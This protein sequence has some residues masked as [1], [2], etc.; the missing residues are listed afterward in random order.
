MLDGAR[1][2]VAEDE[3]VIAWALADAFADAGAEVVG[4]AASVREASQ[5]LDDRAIDVAILDVNLLDG[6]VTPIAERLI[7]QG[8]PVLIDSVEELGRFRLLS[9][10]R[11]FVEESRRCTGRRVV[12]SRLGGHGCR[13]GNELRQFAEVL[14]GGGEEELVVGAAWSSQTE[15]VEAQDALE[16]CEQHLD[17]LTLSP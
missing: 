17:L 11:G 5:L 2:L 9:T 7:A 13:C 16:M 14:G 3:A 6:E 8:V 15:A 10:L 4:P 12:G 1:I